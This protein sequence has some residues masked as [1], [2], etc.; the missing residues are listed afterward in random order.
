MLF[1]ALIVVLAVVAQAA[2]VR[3]EPSVNVFSSSMWL[4]EKTIDENSIIKATIVLKTDKSA[5]EKFEKELLDL[6]TPTSANYGKWLKHDEV[7]SRLAPSADN[8]KV[9]TDYLASFNIPE[10][11]VRVS[12]L[13]DMIH[14]HMPVKTA[15]NVFKTK[16]AAFRSIKQ[17]D[18]LL[19]R[20]TQP[21][22]L[23][24]EVASVVNIVGD[25]MRF[26]SI[27]SSL[28][29]YGAELKSDDEFSSCG[30]KCSGFTTPDVLQSAYGYETVKN[31]AKGNSMS[32]AEFQLQYYDTTDL[33]SFG[34]AC[35]VTATVDET[36]GG[37]KERICEAGG[38][39][40]A[41]LD[42]EYIEAVANPIPLTVI[43]LST[44]SLLDW[45]DQVLAMDDAPLVHSVSY[46]NDEVQ[47]TSA[48]Y[49]ESVNTQFM[50]AGAM[51]LSILFASGDQGVWGRSGVGSTYHPDFPAA[52]PYVTAVGG[53]DFQQKSTIGNESAWSCGGGGFSDEFEMP[54]WQSD[55]V[56]SY[57]KSAAAAGVLPDSKL[58]NAAGRA[59]PDVAA[60][61]GQV[62]PYCVGIRGGSFGGVAGT[63]ASCPVVAGIFA[64][65]NNVRLAAGKSSLGWLNPFIYSNGDCFND[66]ND[67]SMN[68]CNAGTTGFSALSGWDPATGF[69]SPNYACLAKVV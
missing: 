24:E 41:L 22:Y 33:D 32:V 43:Y 38:C 59:Y 67:G 66:V 40:E 36:I 17:R 8:V 21:Y 48:A 39:V 20:I 69:G 6:S 56:S 30:A 68:N 50:K 7:A 64:Q 9:V 37:N 11:D 12:R 27:R 16:F 58:F 28:P 18:V 2:D 57:L 5:L 15:N 3:M 13:G 14:V 23:P 60:L 31:V 26:P 46:G 49:M 61:G 53:T 51:G 65:L 54:D 35:S 47:Q 52:S 55:V 44:F 25:I 19:A 42:I 45:V 62:N 10:K 63:S 1:V 4:K 34:D 29:T